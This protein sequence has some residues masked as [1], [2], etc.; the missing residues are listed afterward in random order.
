VTLCAA[1]PINERVHSPQRTPG[2]ILTAQLVEEVLQVVVEVF[3]SASKEVQ[4]LVVRLH[5]TIELLQAEG[6][7][8]V[9]LDELLSR[10]RKDYSERDYEL[11]AFVD[12]YCLSLQHLRLL[13]E[14][15]LGDP[16]RTL[17]SVLSLWRTS[18]DNS[19]ET[20]AL[21]IQQFG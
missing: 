20:W 21:I 7:A 17:E 15:M 12:D 1:V 5:D 2:M 3:P 18:I 19:K 8:V 9:S 6:A 11:Q 4:E 13:R 16:P 14:G 10:K